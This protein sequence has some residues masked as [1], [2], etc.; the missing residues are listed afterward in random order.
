MCHQRKVF[1]QLFSIH[2]F[3]LVKFV[4]RSRVNTNILT[5]RLCRNRSCD[6][7]ELYRSNRYVFRFSVYF[8]YRMCFC[9]NFLL[10]CFFSLLFPIP[11][12]SFKFE[13]FRRDDTDAAIVSVNTLPKQVSINCKSVYKFITPWKTYVWVW[14][15]TTRFVLNG[16]FYFYVPI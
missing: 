8:Q 3:C 2:V 11:L 7:N 13:R 6:D 5:R 9:H 1:N 16:F 12:N 4:R 15:E 14:F 10:F